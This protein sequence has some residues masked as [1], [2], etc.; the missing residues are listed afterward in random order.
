MEG[1]AQ[2]LGLTVICE[3][4]GLPEEDRPRFHQWV[5]TITAITSLWGLFRFLPAFAAWWRPSSVTSSNA[6]RGPGR[7]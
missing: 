2:P 6:A 1:L 5:R 4:L 3:V 7:D